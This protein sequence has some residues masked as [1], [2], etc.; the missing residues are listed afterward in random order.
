MEKKMCA[1]NRMPYELKESKGK[2]FVVT[3]ATGKK[4]S[5]KPLPKATAEAQK[6]VLEQAEDF[7]FSGD[8]R[9]RK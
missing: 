3:T 4:H 1:R 2:Y 6:R 7:K 9:P 5:K 8:H